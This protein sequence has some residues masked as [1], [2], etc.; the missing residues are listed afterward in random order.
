MSVNSEQM[1]KTILRAYFRNKAVADDD[2]LLIAK[3]WK[4]Y[5]WD[6][7]KTLFKNLKS[8]PSPE[9]ITRTRRKLIAE[10]LIVPSV[11]AAERRYNSFKSTR[12]ALGY[13]K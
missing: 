10:G 1:R 8:M 7:D 2:A 12:K 9:T 6:N 4:A 13:A 3:V 5:G 11:E